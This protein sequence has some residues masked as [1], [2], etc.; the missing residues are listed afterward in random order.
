MRK[1]AEITQETGIVWRH[2]PTDK[3]LSDFRSHGASIDKIQKGQWF[4]G[5]ELLLNKEEWPIHPKL[6][7][8]QSVSER[9]QTRKIKGAVL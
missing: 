7:R 4:E 2:C 1:I 3:N 6:E 8:T 9:A 5:P